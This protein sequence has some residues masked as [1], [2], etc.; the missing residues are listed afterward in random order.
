MGSRATSP[1][2]V[3]RPFPASWQGGMG[4]RA[5]C[6]CSS[7]S[8]PVPFFDGR[9]SLVLGFLLCMALW[10]T[11]GAD[12]EACSCCL[13]AAAAF[14]TE[15]LYLPISI[16]KKVIRWV[17]QTEGVKTEVDRQGTYD[18]HT[19][20]ISLILESPSG[21]DIDWDV[22]SFNYFL[23]LYGIMLYEVHL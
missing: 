19:T 8:G 7:I 23:L 2:L 16:S 13:Q 14:L 1:F 4:D 15:A 9:S 10:P 11:L 12:L 5:F 17:M 6:C 21:S 18:A 20:H 22:S 3:I